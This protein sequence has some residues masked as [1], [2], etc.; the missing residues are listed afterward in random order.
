MKKAFLITT[1]SVSMICVG[2]AWAKG[3]WEYSCPEDVPNGCTCNTK[4]MKCFDTHGNMISLEDQKYHTYTY[5]ENNN[6]T[7]SSTYDD[8]DF[9]HPESN[10]PTSYSIYT[11]DESGRKSSETVH[12]EDDYGSVYDGQK[13]YTYDENNRVVAVTEYEKDESVGAYL[14]TQTV[15]S[16]NANDDGYTEAKYALDEVTKGRDGQLVHYDTPQLREVGDYNCGATQQA[17]HPR[18]DHTITYF[19]DN[20]NPSSQEYYLDYV[21]SKYSDWEE[22][23]ERD[24][25]DEDCTFVTPLPSVAVIPYN[26][27]IKPT[28]GT[29]YGFGCD[30]GVGSTSIRTELVDGS[31][32]VIDAEGNIHYEGK[33]IYTVEEATEV[34]KPTGNTFKIRY[35]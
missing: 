33:R 15:Y 4:G 1:L 13:Y 5:D 21:G 29:G 24:C 23:G 3:G 27:D 9:D 34:V 32:K 11:Y 8:Y 18:C 26:P 25:Y 22:S 14:G 20:G 19:D 31:T 6:Q 10:T 16:Y 17:E 7:S 35:R 2:S 30:A 28:C 12:Q